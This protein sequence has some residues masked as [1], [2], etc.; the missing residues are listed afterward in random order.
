MWFRLGWRGVICVLY[1]V[2]EIVDIYI[3]RVVFIVLINY[4][5]VF[6]LDKMYK[7]NEFFVIFEKSLFDE[8]CLLLLNIFYKL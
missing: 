6:L 4:D 7:N 5:Y 8:R 3:V 2:D 1:R